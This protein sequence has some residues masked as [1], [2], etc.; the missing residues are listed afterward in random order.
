[1]IWR[2]LIAVAPDLATLGA[3]RFE[4]TGLA[5]VATLRKDG[6]PR[7]S[8]VEPFIVDG[9]LLLGMM[10]KSQKARD[11]LRDSRVTVHSPTANRD[12]AEGDFKLYGRVR[13]VTNPILRRSY[14]DAVEAKIAWRPQEPYHLFSVDIVSTAFVIFG[15]ERYGLTWT[16]EGGLERWTPGD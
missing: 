15:K 7:V 4:Q 11:L 12:G 5:L 1:M 14:E 10:W 16:P 6:W 13:S 9:E 8:P 3:R 2:E